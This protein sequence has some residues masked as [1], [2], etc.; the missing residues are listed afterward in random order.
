M[1]DTTWKAPWR[2]AS[3]G[4]HPV[5]QQETATRRRRQRP[6]LR[7]MRETPRPARCDVRLPRTARYCS[8]K[9][10]PATNMNAVTIQSMAGLAYP[11]I[12][13]G[14]G[15]NPPA[16]SV[17]NAWHTASNSGMPA[18]TSAH[19][20]GDREGDIELPQARWP[21][22]RSCGVSFSSVGPAASAKNS[23]PAANR[24]P[25]Q[26]GDEQ[27]D[28]AEPADPVRQ[29]PPEEDA[30]AE[31]GEVR[32]TR[33]RRSSSART[34]T[35]TARR[36]SRGRPTVGNRRTGAPSPSRWPATI[37]RPSTRRSRSTSPPPRPAGATHHDAERRR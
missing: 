20:L 23:S 7:R 24:E 11:A 35:R 31:R 27:R 17:A 10:A 3:R 22:C 5:A 4:A 18:S 34:S 28:D 16:A 1:I 9:F 13:C 21:V 19:D 12:D 26:H 2:S 6:R 29:R 30:A 15:E 33:S 37:A 14:C 8:A 25:R 32:R 36:R